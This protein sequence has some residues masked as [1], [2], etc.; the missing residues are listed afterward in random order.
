MNWHH[1]A[2]TQRVLSRLPFGGDINFLLSRYVTGHVPASEQTLRRDVEFAKLHLAACRDCGEVPVEEACFYEFGAGWDLIIA[3][4]FYMMG[5]NRQLLLDLHPLLRPK[6]VA[7]TA[8]ALESNRLGIDSAR[9]LAELRCPGSYSELCSNLKQRFGITYSAPADASETGLRAQSIDCVTSTKVLC[10][11]PLCELP[12][13]LSESHRLL[14]DRGIASFVIDYRDQYSYSDPNISPYNFL[15]FS[16]QQWSRFNPPLHYQNRLRH[17][18]YRRLFEASGFEILREV[19]AQ[20]SAAESAA[21][22]S[23]QLNASFHNY[24]AEDLYAVRGEFVLR[25]GCTAAVA[26]ARAACSG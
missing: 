12:A 24:E 21:I 14:R 6:L 16:E 4:S 20:P 7:L 3:L 22:P 5:V 13:I 1:K 23:L 17:S 8:A 11:I 19:R 9:G 26:A 2:A 25:R 15:Q 18:D 10:H